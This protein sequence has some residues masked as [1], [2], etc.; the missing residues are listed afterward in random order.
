MK[1]T[2]VGAGY[3]GLSLSVLLKKAAKVTIHDVDPDRLAKISAGISPIKDTDI[4]L[5][6]TDIER[7]PLAEP[8]ALKAFTGAD[9]ILVATPTNYIPEQNYFDTKSV[10]SVIQF[11]ALHSPKA[12]IIIKSTIPIGFTDLVR[13]QFPMS[14]ILFSPEFLREGKALHDNLHPSRI[15]VGGRSQTGRAFA[16]LLQDCATDRD[17]PILLTDSRE[18]EAIKLFSNTYLAMR[19]AFVNELDSFALE[20]GLDVRSILEGICLDPRIGSHYNNPS[21]GFGGYCLPKDTM[22]LLANYDGIPQDIIRAIVSS[23]STRMSYIARRIKDSGA[24]TVGIYKLGMKAGSDN[25]RDSAVLG[26]VRH[27]QS[28]GTNLVL[29]EPTIEGP[30]FLEIPICRELSEFKS[31]ADVILANRL[32]GALE[33]VIQKVFTRDLYM[34]D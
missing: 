30:T 21:F 7:R 6:L 4:E 25:F 9:W 8:S 11:A 18:A 15:V 16:K 13:K 29:Y 22:Q 31:K 24:K 12:K 10:E 32:D 33:D 26:V 20:K 19:I 17:V 3:V 28:F 27:L 5:A 2:V 14:E 23:N 1:I 34:R